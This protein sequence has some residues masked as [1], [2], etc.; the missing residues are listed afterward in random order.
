MKTKTI[1][2]ALVLGIIVF[3]GCENG[4]EPKNEAPVISGLTA[5]P[6]SVES[7]G[8]ST[9]TCEATD[10]DGDELTYIWEESS[11]AI[12]GSGSSVTWTAPDSEGTYSVSCTVD[13]RNGGSDIESVNISVESNNNPQNIISESDFT[14]DGTLDLKVD[15]GSMWIQIN[16]D[17]IDLTDPTVQPVAGFISEGGISN[18]NNFL[19]NLIYSGGMVDQSEY[20]HNLEH[21]IQIIENTPDVGIY[22]VTCVDTANGKEITKNYNV[23]LSSDKDYALI[24]YQFINTGNSS[25]T[26]DERGGHIHNGAQ[27]A[28]ITSAEL[29]DINAYINGVGT[30]DI[31]S[32]TWWHSYTPNQ[33]SPFVVLS[34]PTT[35]NSVTF[36]FKFLMSHSIHQVVSYYTG[37][38]EEIMPNIDINSSEFT[39]APGETAVWKAIISF[40]TGGYEEGVSIYDSA[41]E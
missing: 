8:T 12:N 41:T 37:A 4:T 40:H 28:N 1:L 6:S 26:Y 10:Q 23:E 29:Y 19:R 25:F 31:T 15:N 38:S 39:L 18:Q 3:Y 36:G 2:I 34:E 35:D 21:S 9:L 7:G 20:W 22:Q 30:I 32:Q 11:G 13:D 17:A 5:E 14:G 24:E 16:R 27:L 33:S